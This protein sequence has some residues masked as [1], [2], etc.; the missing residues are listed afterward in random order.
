M[1]NETQNQLER[2]LIIDDDEGRIR[3][4]RKLFGQRL[5]DAGVEPFNPKNYQSRSGEEREKNLLDALQKQK[6][7]VIFIDGQIGLIEGTYFDGVLIS[8]RLRNGFYG[9][10][11]QKTEIV[12]I[13]DSTE[14]P[15]AYHSAPDLTLNEEL[16]S[17]LKTGESK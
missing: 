14:N 5:V 10:T 6:Y 9:N 11:N 13:S 3:T 16:I 17:R 15:F 2:I 12:N 4:A 8:Q 7:A 1:T